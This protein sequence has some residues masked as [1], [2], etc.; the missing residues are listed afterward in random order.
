MLK[1]AVPALAA[2]LLAATP[3]GGSEASAALDPAELSAMTCGDYLR[4][5]EAERTALLHWVAGYHAGATPGA[6]VSARW[7]AE[8]PLNAIMVECMAN[9]HA[10]LVRVIEHHR[11][12]G[13]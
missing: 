6:T 13:S 2:A 7:F 9:P 8:T 4:H 11:R 3:A 12:S 10:P 1:L 5:G